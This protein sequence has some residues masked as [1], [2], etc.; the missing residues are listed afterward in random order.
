MTETATS[1]KLILNAEQIRQKV[2]RIAYEIYERNFEEE[3]L[4][5][6]G[7][8][9]R[10]YLLAERIAYQ[11]NQ[12]SPFTFAQQRLHLSRVSLQKFTD[13]QADITLDFANEQL[14]GKSI[15]LV[16][17]VLNTGKTLAYCVS[18]FLRHPIKKIETAVLVNRSHIRFPVMANYTG[19]ELATTLQEHIEV[20][21]EE[22]KE[23]VYLK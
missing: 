5:V 1:P 6:A 23:A 17:D 12:I 9:D 8:V 15:V 18:P 20:V 4:I 22:G 19:Y 11:L 3:Q 21:L 10:G 13:R 16:D 14:A 7:V 2:I